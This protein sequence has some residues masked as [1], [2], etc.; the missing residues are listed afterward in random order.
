VPV[1]RLSLEHIAER[2]SRLSC[3]KEYVMV[4]KIFFLI[5]I[6]LTLPALAQD[7]PAKEPVAKPAQAEGKSPDKLGAL[8]AVTGEKAAEDPAALVKARKSYETKVKAVVDPLKTEYLK[9]LEGLKKD[10]GAKGDVEAAQTME[11]EM[12]SQT[13]ILTVIGKWYWLSKETVEFCEDGTAKSSFGITGKWICTDRKANRYQAVW[14]NGFTDGV[15]MSPD[16]F[17]LYIV[18]RKGNTRLTHT[19]LRLPEP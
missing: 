16:G 9:N 1:R 7:K 11:R 2:F 3:R 13:S 15:T 8:P 18:G 19:A 6:V 4:R 5:L 17:Y 10:F 12:K 14:S